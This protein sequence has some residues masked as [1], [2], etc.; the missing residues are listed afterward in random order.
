MR[1][2]PSGTPSRTNRYIYPRPTLRMFAISLAAG[3]ALAALL[4]IAMFSRAK[5]LASPGALSTSH[6]PFEKNCASCHGP[7]IA[8]V[9]CEH[10]H[11]PSGTGRLQNAG[12]VWF[13][14]RD[15]GAV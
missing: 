10:C 1:L 6:A 2:V 15:P 14:A 13:G 8:D 9:R 5:P 12:H 3:L 7:R 11:D 4:I